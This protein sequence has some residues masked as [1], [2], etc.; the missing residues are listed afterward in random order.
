MAARKQQWTVKAA[1]TRTCLL[2]AVIAFALICTASPTLATP[3]LNVSPDNITS[4]TM[5]NITGTNFTPNEDITLTTTVTCYKPIVNAKCECTM[6][7]FE[8]RAG[9][10]FKLSVSEVTDNV[11]LY[12]KKVVWWPPVEPGTPGFHFD[13]NP[14]THTSNVSTTLAVP[15]GGRYNI[16][17]IGDS[18]EGS[19]ACKMV[20]TATL[21]LKAD[22]NGN[23]SIDEIDTTGIPVCPFTIKA[24]GA[25]SGTAE[26]NLNLLLA[27]DASK[28]GQVNAYDCCCIARYC[29]CIPGYDN[30][31]ISC[32]CADV[33]GIP[34]VA[35]TD[36]RYLARSLV[37]LENELH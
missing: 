1:L 34:G 12:I 32:S 35:S 20:T 15:V 6:E 28:D 24:V 22:A 10:W 9:V 31:T 16:D 23:F 26:A 27:G 14:V 5:V 2:T 37:G 30:S 3:I 36:A 19:G 13:Y 21:Y 29:C 33:D 17:V 11:S 18:V 8:I 25:S 4:G 7:D